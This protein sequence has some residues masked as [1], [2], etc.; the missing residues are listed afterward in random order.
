M[1]L[2]HYAAQQGQS[3]LVAI[4]LTNGAAV[5]FYGDRGCQALGSA[6]GGGDTNIIAMFIERGAD[7]NAT[8]YFGR[9]MNVAAGFCRDTN[10]LGFLIRSGAELNTPDN[11][12]WTA[13]DWASVWNQGALSFLEVAGGRPGTNR[14][15]NLPITP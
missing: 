12:G 5:S 10:V 15:M 7:V 14:R 1:P 4:M 8:N 13:L 9:S 2:L 6:V 3:K 11:R